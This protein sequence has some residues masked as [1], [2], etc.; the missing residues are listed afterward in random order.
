MALMPS[1]PTLSDILAA[2]SDAERLVTDAAAKGKQAKLSSYDWRHD[3]ARLKA[4]GAVHGK[5]I[6]F[7][8]LGGNKEYPVHQRGVCGSPVQLCSGRLLDKVCS[9]PPNN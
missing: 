8:L 7:L 3:L 9:C 5:L 1:N 2:P 4:E 6:R